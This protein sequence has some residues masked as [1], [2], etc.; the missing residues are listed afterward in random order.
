MSRFSEV[1]EIE[2]SSATFSAMYPSSAPWQ[3]RSSQNRRKRSTREAMR[4]TICGRSTRSFFST[5]MRRR[6]CLLYLSSRPF[7]IDDLPVPRAP[8]RSTLLAGLPSMNCR[9]FC[10]TR[11]ICRSMPRRSESRIRCTSRTGGS[12]PGAPRRPLERERYA[13]LAA[14]SVGAGGPGRSC[15]RRSRIF[16]SSLLTRSGSGPVFG[17]DFHVVEGKVASPERGGRLAAIHHRAHREFRFF[18]CRHTLLL[19]ICGMA[20]APRGNEH[21]VE[22]KIYF[23]SLDR[24][25]RISDRRQDAAQVRI[26]GEKCRLH[27]RGMGNRV[28]H[29]PAFLDAAAAVDPY[30]DELGRAFCVAHDGLCKL[31]RNR[32][33]RDLQLQQVA[34]GR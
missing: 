25:P 22:I 17:V 34:P 32:G 18:H 15:S 30:R 4:S 9:V 19:A 27:Q 16:T 8:V 13:T 5:S 10:S 1:V 29:A 2:P 26:R 33:D 23:A 24:R 31:L 7:T 6:P 14:Q 20:A 12:Q 21:V 11:S 3:L 28:R